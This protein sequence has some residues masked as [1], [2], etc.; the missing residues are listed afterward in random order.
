M[1]NV[2]AL[3]KPDA[4]PVWLSPAQV[5]DRIPG[6]TLDILSDMR[7]NRRGPAYYKPSLRTVIYLESEIDAWVKGTR[8]ETRPE[9]Q[10]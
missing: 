3:R 5:C 7:E 4:Q 2:T 1:S 6:M 8:V 10:S 9:G